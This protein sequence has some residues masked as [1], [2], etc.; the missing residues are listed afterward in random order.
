VKRTL[1]PV[2]ALL[3]GTGAAHAAEPSAAAEGPEPKGQPAWCAPEVEA[4]SDGLCHIDGGDRD[5]RRT[6]VIFLHG[7]IA[8]NTTWQWTQERALLRQARQS[9]FE[10]I[11]FIKEA[12]WQE[13]WRSRNAHLFLPIKLIRIADLKS[14]SAHS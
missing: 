6:L 3:A 4:L 11:R 10:A 8:K 13:Q 5:G 1:V 2:L 12:T 14:N 9:H 7:A